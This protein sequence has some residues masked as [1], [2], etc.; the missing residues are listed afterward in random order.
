[1]RFHQYPG[2]ISKRILNNEKGR[3]RNKFRP[4]PSIRP[5]CKSFV[6]QLVHLRNPLS[7]RLATTFLV[8]LERDSKESKTPLTEPMQLGRNP[9][10]PGMKG[11]NRTTRT[12]STHSTP[13]PEQGIP[14]RLSEAM[15]PN[16]LKHIRHRL[17][18]PTKEEDRSKRRVDKILSTVHINLITLAHPIQPTSTPTPNSSASKTSSANTQHTSSQKAELPAA[19]GPPA[20]QYA[21]NKQASALLLPM[22]QTSSTQGPSH[23]TS[24]CQHNIRWDNINLLPIHIPGILIS[25]RYRR[26]GPIKSVNPASRPTEGW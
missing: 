6:S 22:F 19:V 5:D 18:A 4:K 26:G 13:I 15:H 23:G 25:T 20:F 17:E 8:K 11:R 2:S 3:R 7:L 12:V 21:L 14:P 24:N 9:I 10:T 1:M 16:L